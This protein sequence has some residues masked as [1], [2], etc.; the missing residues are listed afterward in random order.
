MKL[1]N[2]LTYNLILPISDFITGYEIKSILNFLLKSQYWTRDEINNHQLIRLKLLIEH[3]YN[4]VPFYHELYSNLRIKPSDIQKI[5]DLSYLPIIT[6]NIMKENNKLFLA[7][8]INKKDLIYCSSSGST[9][10]P[11]QFYST[12]KAESFLKASA[13]R[14]WYWM[15]YNLGD[16]YVKISMNPRNSKIKKIQDLINRSKY[17]SSNQLIR[18]NFIKISE[19]IQSF[20]PEFIRCYPHPLHYLATIIKENK[21][22]MS[23]KSLKA[24]NTT[25]STLKN[26]IRNTIEEVF[27]VKIFDT[28][29]CEGGTI[30]SECSNHIYHP[31]EEYAISEFISDKFTELDENRPYRHI[32]TD[33]YNYAFP[34]IRYD[35][36]DYLEIDNNTDKCNCNRN[37]KK[38][39]RIRG[40]DSDIIITPSKKILIV[41]NFVAYFEWIKEVD[42]IQIIQSEINVITINIIVNKNFNN[43]I[44]SK[45]TEYW[46]KYIGEDV[47]V[48]VKVVDE[49]KLTPTGKRRIVIRDPKIKLDD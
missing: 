41:E 15:G 13:I 38:I 1:I 30:F 32:T 17:L 8:N 3:A 9:G 40:R 22:K 7:K 28:Y 5:S 31:A 29:S 47:H 24:I 16:K 6:K 35:T 42:Q 43:E 11:F 34:F 20:N 37:F 19:Q 45:I 39:K 49:I 27:G 12:K 26:E 33:L 21:D 14:A 44:L 2:K 48:Y 46:K 25:G 4:N 23:F 18:S 10:E 36:Q